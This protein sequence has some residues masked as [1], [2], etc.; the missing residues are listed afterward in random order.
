VTNVDARTLPLLELLHVA[1]G[2]PAAWLRFLVALRDAISKDVEVFF[3]AQS[4][5]RVPGTLAGSDSGILRVQ[6][7]EVLR[8]SLPHPGLLELPIGAV[9]ALG[10]EN[11]LSK[12]ALFRDVLAPRGLLP[13]PGFVLVLERTERFVMSAVLVL[14]RSRGWKPRT[15]ARALLERLGPHMVV[16]RKLQIRLE[17]RRRHADALISA[18]D[19]L[20][21]GVL[22]LDE[23]AR[24]SYTNRSASE[25]LGLEA[26]FTDPA[27]LAAAA[28]DARTRAWQAVLRS[29]RSEGEEAFLYAHPEDGRPLQ[30]LGTPF[31]WGDDDPTAKSRFARAVFIGDAKALSG[32]PTGLLRDL[33]GL[34]KGEA[35]LSLLLISGCSVR[36]AARIL[37]VKESTARSVLRTVFTKTGTNRQAGLI[38]LLLT[39]PLGGVRGR[40]AATTAS[41]QGR[42]SPSRE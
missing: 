34:T 15:S 14:P 42:R 2:D 33:F 39:G 31:A 26:G 21:L 30:V 17:D 40:T 29:V 24:V 25:M 7:D 37:G 20:A 16:A 9:Q 23:N 36:E 38:R 41:T 22:F 32:D 1:P 3:A 28:P 27:S 13:G 35:R 4:Q 12:S 8:P 18:F 19:H 5:G 6:L 11:P 10:A